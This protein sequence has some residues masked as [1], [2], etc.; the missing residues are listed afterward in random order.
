MA[1]GYKLVNPYIK[2]EF[3]TLFNEKSHLDAAKKCWENLSSHFT[4]NIPVFAF[5]ME[6]VKDNKLHHFV[7]KESVK[8][9]MVEYKISELDVN[10]SKKEENELRSQIKNVENDEM[11]GG[12]RR[13]F[14]DDDDDDDTSSTTEAYYKYKYNQIVNRTN[15]PIVWWWYNPYPYRLRTFFV[16]TFTVPLTPYVE[17]YTTTFMYP[18]DK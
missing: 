17:I 6:R 7:V 9:N 3:N 16:P 5:S 15:Q 14:D 1:S 4:N 13:R 18:Y 8:N 12:K 11:K 10:M 2:G